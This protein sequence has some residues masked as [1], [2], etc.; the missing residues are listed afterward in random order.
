MIFKAFLMQKCRIDSVSVFMDTSNHGAASRLLCVNRLP[1]TRPL[2]KP[3][4]ARP[5]EPIEV[6]EECVIDEAG[7]GSP[8]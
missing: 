3:E 5:I 6:K 2:M 7:L 8:T 4:T 1:E